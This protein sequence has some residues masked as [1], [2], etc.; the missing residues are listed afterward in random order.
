VNARF[1]LLALSLGCLL[2]CAIE[3]PPIPPEAFACTGDAPD[4]DGQ[5]QCPATHRCQSGA[6][7]GRLDCSEPFQSTPGCT[8]NLHR[9]DLVLDPE[10]AGASCQ[11]GL[12]T[13]TSARPKDVA[14]CACPDGTYCV[15]FGSLAGSSST[16]SSAS[17]AYPL[18]LL[19]PLD[20][21]PQKGGGNGPAV[22]F[23]AGKFQTVGEIASRRMCS[24]V[25]ATE[26]DCPASHT[27][28][29][30][31]VVQAS[32]LADPTSTRSTI[33]VCW[34]DRLP[35]TATVA[36]QPDPLECL[37]SV[38][39][40]SAQSRRPV[41]L[42]QVQVESVPDHP[43][44]P[45]GYA[46]GSDRGALVARCTTTA[47]TGLTSDNDGCL[48][49]DQCRSGACL[50]QPSGRC[51]KLC[52]PLH[53]VDVCINAEACHPHL[54]TRELPTAGSVQDLIYACDPEM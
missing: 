6:C 42:C 10:L 51:A 26:F 44:V 30:A 19:P 37:S 28:R 54:I 32:L 23:P 5:L 33:G 15:A 49:S 40:S 12:H 47:P 20:A 34:P 7:V 25:C 43:T 27:C 13:S 16:A 39:C 29:A 1:L 45:A 50:G 41:G 14:S 21:T 2:S 24:R 4:A 52:D 31:A 3:L 38:D 35:G 17:N 9:C 8:P 36:E 22:A 18:F 48:R 53:A 11:S 46:W